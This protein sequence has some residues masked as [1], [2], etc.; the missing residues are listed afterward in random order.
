MPRVSAFLLFKIALLLIIG[1]MVL[2]SH[3]F[4]FIKNKFS[5]KPTFTTHPFL[6]PFIIFRKK[7]LLEGLLLSYSKTKKII[8]KNLIIV[9]S[10]LFSINLFSQNIVGDWEGSL[11]V[12]GMQL[13]LIFHI[14]KD[15]E[16]FT[17]TMD[18]PDQGANGIPMDKTTVEDG[19]LTIESKQLGMKYIAPISE[20]GK[21]LAGT[22]NQRGMSFPLELAKSDA[23]AK[24]EM[25]KGNFNAPEILGDWNGTLEVRGTQLRVVF[26]LLNENGNLKATMDS[27]DQGASGIPMSSADYVDGELTIKADNMKMK[28]VAKISDDEAQFKG[29]YQQGAMSIP[30]DL[31]REKIA[32]KKLNRPQEPTDFPYQQEEVKFVNPNGGHQLAGTL[33]IPEDGKFEKVVVLIT[34]SGPQNRDEELLGHKPFL[35]L[36]DRM[37]RNGI[38]VLR[39]DD[40]GIGESEG[41][42]RGATSKDFADDVTAAVSFLKNRKDMEGKKIGL[43]GHS[44]GGMIAPMVASENESVDFIIL[45]AGPG[46]DIV[47]LMMLQTDMIG[48]SEGVSEAER[49]RN[50]KANRRVFEYLRKNHDKGEEELKKELQQISDE[51]MKELT[52]EEK[53]ELPNQENMFAENM[54]M[55]LDKWFLYFMQFS[56]DDFLKKVNCPVLAVNGSLDLQVTAKENLEGIERSLKKA[57]NKNVTVREFEG[58]NHLFQKS[59]TGAPA[60]YAVLEETFNEEVINY[61]V[62]WI[63]TLK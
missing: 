29:S 25:P 58:L 39:Y 38:A 56:P 44:E 14:T 19:N 60:E 6:E 23:V 63:R 21:K 5:E 50:K 15:G 30:L 8:M 34:G 41:A 54:G 12:Q 57:N 33:T 26:H 28:Y 13:K 59:E 16:K 45:L 9:C 48:A 4:V 3:C 22:F 35:V 61:L 47:E 31:S 24:K 10:L 49:A 7:E 62:E 11:E 18:S 20:N 37:T 46:I 43:M 27:P 17:S 36:S 52:A 1:K 42:F 55:M 53:A 32:K 51:L 40:R 2:K